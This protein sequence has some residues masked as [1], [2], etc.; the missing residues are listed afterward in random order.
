MTTATNER[1]QRMV[2]TQAL[3]VQPGDRVLEVG[4]GSGYAAAVLSRVH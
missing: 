4:S 3:E 2:E 1:R